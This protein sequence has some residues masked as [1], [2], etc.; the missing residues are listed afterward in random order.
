MKFK[1]RIIK[2]GIIGSIIFFL[3]VNNFWCIFFSEEYNEFSFCY[4]QGFGMP[5]SKILFWGE[6]F[7]CVFLIVKIFIS[8][9]DFYSFSFKCIYLLL[10]TYIFFKYFRRLD[11][12]FISTAEKMILIFFTFCTL[13]WINCFFQKEKINV[14]LT[15]DTIPKE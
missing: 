1:E 6:V 15:A 5:T 11:F 3:I 13:Y 4:Y 8:T 14:S 7:C 9:N 12:S 10:S 2:L